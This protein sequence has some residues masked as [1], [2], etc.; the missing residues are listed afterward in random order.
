LLKTV[1]IDPKGRVVIPKDVREQ[2]G[3]TVPGELLVTIEGTGKITLQSPETT[4][5]RAQQIGRKKLRSWVENKHEED[6]LAHR[7][8]RE[9]EQN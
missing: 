6:K 8:A 1:E 7:L 3:I 5:K 4:L 9:E 2:S